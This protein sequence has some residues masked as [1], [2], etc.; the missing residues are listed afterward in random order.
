MPYKITDYSYQKA[1]Q[2]NVDIKPS[3]NKN[4]KIDVFKNNKKIA[5]IG[6]INY[7]DYPNFIKKNGLEYANQK[8]KLYKL[9]HKKD[10]NSKNGKWASSILW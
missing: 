5:S 6:S 8:K 10:L 1:K 9:R 4:K 2:L 3:T 7:L